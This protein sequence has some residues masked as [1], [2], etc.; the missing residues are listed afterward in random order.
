MCVRCLRQPKTSS[1]PTVVHNVVVLC[2]VAVNLNF[3]ETLHHG[4]DLVSCNVVLEFV[5]IA[6][7]RGTGSATLTHST[8]GHHPTRM[9]IQLWF[10]RVLSGMALLLS[11]MSTENGTVGLGYEPQQQDDNPQQQT[12]DPQSTM[13]ETIVTCRRFCNLF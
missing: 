11:I 8:R 1:A 7:R 13:C 5:G 12:G 2:I 4:M 3:G 9:L 10:V 6:K